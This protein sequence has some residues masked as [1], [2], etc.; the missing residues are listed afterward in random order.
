MGKVPDDERIEGIFAQNEEW[1][2]AEEAIENFQ[3]NI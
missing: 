1:I 2:A 3:F